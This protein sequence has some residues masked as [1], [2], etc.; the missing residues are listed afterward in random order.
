MATVPAEPPARVNS[1]QKGAA[2]ALYYLTTPSPVWKLKREDDD[3]DE[4][5]H[6]PATTPLSIDD[7]RALPGRLEIDAQSTIDD[8]DVDLPK[9]ARSSALSEAG[10]NVTELS[11]GD[12]AWGLAPAAVYAAVLRRAI[13][14]DFRP[15]FAR[16]DIALPA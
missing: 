16:L 1:A 4:S 9:A 5:D 12:R 3:D 11:A 2:E 6:V 15:R 8:L 7:A 10:Q 13:E 14:R